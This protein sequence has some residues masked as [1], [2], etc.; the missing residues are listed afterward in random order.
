MKILNKIKNQILLRLGYVLVNRHYNYVLRYKGKQYQ[1]SR[2]HRMYKCDD[3]QWVR[4]FAKPALHKTLAK[5]FFN[6]QGENLYD[7]IFKEAMSSW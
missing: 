2:L 7:V 3:S 1:T 5:K 6:A 4:A